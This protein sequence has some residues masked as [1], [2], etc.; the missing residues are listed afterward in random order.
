MIAPPPTGIRAL[1]ILTRVSLRRRLNRLGSRFLFSFGKMR[2]QRPASERTATPRKSRPKILV[3]LLFGLIF[4]FN[5]VNIWSM[6]LRN[7]GEHIESQTKAGEVQA[8]TEP[9]STTP[10]VKSKEQVHHW[11]SA[12]FW[13]RKDKS[14][15]MVRAVAFVLFVL[16]LSTLFT[17][18][19]LR[20]ID[21]G[22]ADWDLEWLFS[23]PVSARTLFTVKVLEY[24]IVSP[25]MWMFILPFLIVIFWSATSFWPAGILLAVGV[26]VYTALMLAAMRLLIETWLKKNLSKT[27]IKNIQAAFTVVGVLLILSA[28]SAAIQPRVLTFMINLSQQL[29]ALIMWL[30]WAAPA[31]LCRAN[32]A[33]WGPFATIV[34]EGAAVM[35]GAVAASSYFVRDGLITASGAYV[36]TRSHKRKRPTIRFRGILGKD[37]TLLLR[38]RNLLVQITIIPAIL[39]A[40]QLM[41]TPSLF[42]PAGINY[43]LASVI[44]F[45]VAA[46]ILMTGTSAI[47]AFEAR[48]MW[49]LFTFPVKLQRI[50]KAKARLWGSIASGLCLITLVVIFA[51][52][53][54]LSPDAFWR[55]GL[56]IAGA[57]IYSHIAAAI[58]A[59]YADP[60]EKDAQKAFRPEMSILFM[61]LAAMYAFVIY[62]PSV[63]ANIAGLL[64]SILIAYAIWQFA[65]ERLPL[66]LDPVEEAPHRIGM[67]DGLVAAYVFFVAQGILGLAYY[68]KHSVPSAKAL[69]VIYFFSA[70]FATIVMTYFFLRE[71]V[72][73]LLR[74]I[75]LKA[76]DKTCTKWPKALATGLFCGLLAA[77]FAVAYLNLIDLSPT[78][79]KL[80]RQSLELFSKTT[81]HGIGWFALLMLLFAP[82][83]EEFIFRGLLFNGMRR[84]S[85]PAVAILVSAGVFALVHPAIS[86]LPVFGLGIATAISFE[87]TGLLIAPIAAHVIY[88]GAVL[89]AQ[90]AGKA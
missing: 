78:L 12:K 89:A 56:A 30:P 28:W 79:L 75:G 5:G 39:V 32:T 11:R 44:A 46:F 8:R 64:M 50:M 81:Q 19:G 14:N 51:K 65:T 55:A 61:L 37:L 40:Y 15:Q 16:G 6:F 18:L 88:N 67:I 29:P 48:S 20:N 24:A 43:K 71:K 76:S 7:L 90:L 70:L 82:V 3:L 27:T 58:S 34:L 31:M 38:D 53:P 22:K 25:F 83:F 86:A 21:L 57:I 10:S 62:A 73:N 9:H 23:L 54:K 47:A 68:A 45:G 36:G 60:F 2:G 1:A 85:R 49:L 26:A 35:V 87:R 13:P 72:P 42:K 4:V 84:R 33:G 52:T 66:I 74:T 77:V 41:V 17:D 59:I 63:Y 80:K 69:L